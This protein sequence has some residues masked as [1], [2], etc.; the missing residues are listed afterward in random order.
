[1]RELKKKKKQVSV[2]STNAKWDILFIFMKQSYRHFV[3]YILLEAAN[4]MNS[5]AELK[6][7]L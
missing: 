6:L 2:A 7:K 1:M 4:Y 5:N 3:Q